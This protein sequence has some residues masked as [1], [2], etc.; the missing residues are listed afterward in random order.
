[1]PAGGIAEATATHAAIAGPG[2]QIRSPRF[3]TL[4]RGRFGSALSKRPPAGGDGRSV[5]ARAPPVGRA[6]I[7]LLV[8]PGIK[9]LGWRVGPVAESSARGRLLGKGGDKASV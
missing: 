2:R 3:R 5:I 7:F 8:L 1:M 9:R 4:C 6:L